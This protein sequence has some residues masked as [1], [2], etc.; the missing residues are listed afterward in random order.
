[1]QRH[2][3][4]VLTWRGVFVNSIITVALSS[5]TGRRA[6]RIPVLGLATR[7]EEYGVDSAKARGKGED[8]WARRLL[9]RKE[10]VAHGYSFKQ[11]V[12]WRVR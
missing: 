4:Y 12:A 7:T 5:L 2:V 9:L 8:L 3:S 6:R 11:A 10:R 1:M